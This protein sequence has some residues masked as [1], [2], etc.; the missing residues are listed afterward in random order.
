MV[1]I[2][3]HSGIYTLEATQRL[4]MP[5]NEAWE[6]FSSPANLARITPPEMGFIITSDTTQ[7]AYEGQI[8]SYKVGIFPLIKSNWVTE[9]TT[10]KEN[11]F[12]IDEQRFGPYRMWHHE[13][14]FTSDGEGTLMF[15][16]VSY[17]IPFGCLGQLVHALF[18][19]RKLFQIFAFRQLTL[20][21]LFG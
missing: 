6:F 11:E 8:I 2:T 14:R 13:H 3:Q 17:K 18:I 19:K 1:K 21:S 7:K 9:I 20:K 15:D 16:K 4:P 12:F 5:L 10:V